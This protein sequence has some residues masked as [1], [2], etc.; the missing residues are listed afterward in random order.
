MHV[1]PAQHRPERHRHRHRHR[2][3]GHRRAR[4]MGPDDRQQRR[5][6]RCRGHRASHTTIPTS[7]RTSGRTRASPAAARRRTASTTTATARSTTSAGWDFAENDNDPHGLRGPRHA[8]GRH[9]RGGR[10][11]RRGR[12]GREL[13]RAHR[14]VA[15]VQPESA[16][17]AATPPQLADA[18][19]YAGQK[20]MKVVNGSFGT[21]T[22]AQSVAD[23]IA[24]APEHAVRV[25]RRATRQQRQRH[26]ADH[27]RA[28]TPRPTSSASP[29]RTRTTTGRRSRTTGTSSVDLAAPG[30]NIV[31]HVSERR[32]LR[33]RLRGGQLRHEVD[34][35]RHEQHVG[36]AV[37]PGQ[38]LHDGQPRGP[39]T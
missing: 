34:H 27:T 14:A 39:T 3:R 21:F 8:R 16:S 4:G 24:N 11:Q 31:E 30:T 20:G 6:G 33:G 10:Q 18:F 37:H 5:D 28:S 23:A 17:S 32:P 36:A 29:Q 22:F 19:A 25:R 1:G 9:D 2:G 15:G 26:D 38:L 12:P 35:R 7:R 13:E